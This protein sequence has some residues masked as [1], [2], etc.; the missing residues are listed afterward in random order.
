MTA[1]VTQARQAELLAIL[2]AACSA[3]GLDDT[4]AT[5]LAYSSN[6]V[7][8]LAAQPIVVRI[9]FDADRETQTNQLVRTAEWLEQERAPISPLAEVPGQPVIDDDWSATFWQ[10]LDVPKS[11]PATAL[12]APLCQFHSLPANADL[13]VWDKFAY[14][15]SHLNQAADID[16][17]DRDWLVNAWAQT[18]SDYH[19]AFADMPL[20]VIHG[21]AHTGNLLNSADGRFVLCDLDNVAYGPIDWDLTPM[22]VSAARFGRPD[23]QASFA[24]AYG[25]DVTTLPWW[26]VLRRMREL[27]MVTYIITDLRSRPAMAEQWEHRM[28]TL[29][30]DQTEARWQRL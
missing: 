28:H 19:A 21:D 25:R 3:A 7:Y 17:G 11:P 29:R 6:V 9:S 2:S 5:L 13:P 24:A 20:G 27:V 30:A 4:D 16:P 1:V 18:E 14:G 15:R 23:D 22:A 8:R 12:A 26:P 10:A